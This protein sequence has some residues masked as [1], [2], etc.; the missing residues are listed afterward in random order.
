MVRIEFLIVAVKT[1]G[2][3]QT[4]RG[5]CLLSFINSVWRCFLQFTSK[6]FFLKSK[7]A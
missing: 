7:L 5:H 2:E 6:T 4:F 3:V 1:L